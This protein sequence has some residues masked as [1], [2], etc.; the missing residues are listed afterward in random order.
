MKKKAALFL[1]L[2]LLLTMSACS[3]RKND[4]STQTINY[5]IDNEPESL[6]PQIAADSSSLV[7][8]QNVFEGLVRLDKDKNPVA[9]VAT[10]WESNADHTSFTFYLR[11]NAKWSDGTAVTA[12]D[13]V[14]AFRRA[15]SPQTGSKTSKPLFCIKNARQVN[16]GQLPETNLG[17][18]AENNSVLVIDLAYSYEDFPALTATAPFM[19][20][21]QKF[22]ES[23]GGRYGLEA[24]K[25]IYN[26][27]Y[28]VGK[29]NWEHNKKIS[30]TKSA[31]YRGLNDAVPA[32]VTFTIG[33]ATQDAVTAITSGTVDAAK[34]P[35]DLYEKAKSANLNIDSFSDTTWGLCFN[36]ANDLFKNANIRKGFLGAIDRSKL[37]A[38]VPQTFT[39]ADDIIPPITTLYGKPY[40]AQAG[41]ALFFKAN[42]D[43]KASIQTGLAELKL[44]SLPSV[45]VLCPDD[46]KVKQMITNMLADWNAKLGNYFNMQPLSA[47]E[48]QNHVSSGDYQMAFCPI[49]AA[50][51]GP[52]ELLSLFRSSSSSNPAKY[53]DAAYDA[54]L[55]A[56]DSAAAAEAPARYAAAEKYLNDNAVFYPVFCENRYY[57]SRKTV[58]GILFRPFDAGVDFMA[59]V[60][61]K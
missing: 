13:F 55:D 21:N 20:C 11:Q 41:A 50:G 14:F 28:Q 18:R 54:L 32:G 47:E 4:P 42:A 35:G 22:F 2:C 24:N 23:T 5:Q 27:P 49:R 53:Q 1:S 7:I 46:S 45:T 39:Q 36:T 16:A 40:R 10:K 3:S 57:A 59:A 43:A 19:P 48:V 15:I 9:G 8:I 17:V 60:K 56:A 30:I 44:K 31:N 38:D 12:D 61:T 25:V 52:S 6:D 29:Y 34:L 33:T 26:G 51:D 37:F 58:S